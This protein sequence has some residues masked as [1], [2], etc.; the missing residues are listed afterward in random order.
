MKYKA[1]KICNESRFLPKW[2]RQ[3]RLVLGPLNMLMIQFLFIRLY[4]EAEYEKESKKY[5]RIKSYGILFPVLP[6]SLWNWE[7][8]INSYMTRD[9]V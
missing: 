1:Y 2:F 9:W 3:V 8:W 4:V 7:Y 5:G 6:L